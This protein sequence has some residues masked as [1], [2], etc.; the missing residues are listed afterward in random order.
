MTNYLCHEDCS[1]YK[2]RKCFGLG[3]GDPQPVNPGNNCLAPHVYMLDNL[4]QP[5]ERITLR[6]KIGLG[7]QV[8]GLAALLADAAIMA[9]YNTSD[10]NSLPYYVIM[11]GLSLVFG[12]SIVDSFKHY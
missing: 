2:K 1:S 12:G 6:E 7:M 11:A 4:R 9:V 8:T 10:K 3:T 5:E